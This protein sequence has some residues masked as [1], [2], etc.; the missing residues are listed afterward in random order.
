[1]SST[2]IC[3]TRHVRNVL[4]SRLFREYGITLSDAI[5]T[6]ETPDAVTPTDHGHL[7]AWRNLGS[8]W[9]S[10]T[11]VQEGQRTIIVTITVRK[12]GPEGSI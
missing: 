5:S 8:I 9:L 12:R 1:V 4:R 3:P 6:L 2:D 10:V 11:Y 7:N